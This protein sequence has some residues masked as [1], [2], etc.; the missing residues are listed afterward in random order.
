M[1]ELFVVILVGI[2][3]FT[4]PRSGKKIH[5]LSK[6]SVKNNAKTFKQQPKNLPS[7]SEHLILA[8]TAHISLKSCA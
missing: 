6:I 7:Q 8:L 5:R 2:L 4:M 1:K 3:N